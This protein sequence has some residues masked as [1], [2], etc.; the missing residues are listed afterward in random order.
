MVTKFSPEINK[1]YFINEY[2]LYHVLSGS[3]SIEVDFKNYFDWQDKIIYL[4][5]GQYIKFSS[6]NFSIRKITFADE[7]VFK[8]TEFRVLFKHLVSLGYINFAECEDCQKYLNQAVFTPDVGSLIDVSSEQWYWQNPFNAKKDEYHLIFDVKDVIDREY[9]NHL[10]SED[11][12]SL[13]QENGHE[14]MSLVKDKIGL[15]VR[16][17]LSQKR[18]LESQKQ[19]SFS[20]KSIKEIA[21]DLGFKDPAYFNRVFNKATGK[22]PMDFRVDFDF[23]GRDLFA[24]DLHDLLRNHH[25]Q[26]RS[27]EF[28]ADKMHLSVKALSR[29][30]KTKMNTSLGQLIR[31]ELIHTAKNLLDLQVSPKQIARQLSF[32]EP[33][34]FSAFFKHYTG[35]TPTEFQ[36]QKYKQ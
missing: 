19:V 15:T 16:G 32:E 36:N 18:L 7:D 4:N 24:Q 31:N 2:S 17:L 9:S 23:E 20:D 10:T 11:L 30:V 29:K 3:G 35:L 6:D 5:K 14:A 8:S 12:T 22:N 1:V 25:S 34:H 33:N 27:L 26:N 28:Y 13:L 21:Y